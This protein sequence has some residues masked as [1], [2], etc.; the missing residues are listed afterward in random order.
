M[1][2][3]FFFFI[4]LSLFL[5]YFTPILAP[6]ASAA[7][8]KQIIE[9]D[10]ATA[11]AQDP[12]LAHEITVG[13]ATGV[14]GGC[15]K[16]K[17]ARCVMGKGPR[18]DMQ[19]FKMKAYCKYNDE[20]KPSSGLQVG[21]G[22]AEMHIK[23]DNMKNLFFYRDAMYWHA[24]LDAH[25]NLIR[26]VRLNASGYVQSQLPGHKNEKEFGAKA[27]EIQGRMENIKNEILKLTQKIDP[28]KAATEKEQ[29]NLA[30]GPRLIGRL[31]AL[32]DGIIKKVDTKYNPD[33]HANKYRERSEE[34]TS[35]YKNLV[36]Q[37]RKEIDNLKVEKEELEKAAS[38][39][40]ISVGADMDSA[41]I[42][43]GATVINNSEQF[44]SGKLTVAVAVATSSALK[45]TAKAMFEG[46][47]IYLP[48]DDGDIYS[49]ISKLK[50]IGVVGSRRFVEK[51]TGKRH[52]L[53]MSTQFAGNS[54][55]ESER[56]LILAENH[57][58]L[59]L[60]LAI[61]ANSLSKNPTRMKY[62][63]TSDEN[64]IITPNIAQTLRSEL[65]KMPLFG[66]KERLKRK[67][68]W[69]G[70]NQ[71]VWIVIYSISP[72]DSAKMR[73]FMRSNAE[74][75]IRINDASNYWKGYAK[76]LNSEVERARNATNTE[77][78]GKQDAKDDMLGR[79]PPKGKLPSDDPNPNSDIRKI[80]EPNSPIIPKGWYGT[81]GG[82]LENL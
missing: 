11:L 61:K 69:P 21:V 15:T 30:Q 3:S 8:P 38:G 64:L 34:R 25:S 63:R 37:Y 35:R 36:K 4:S 65:K 80:P 49:F 33:D 13:Q 67:I 79:Y 39:R 53:G 2:H 45:D 1:K 26:E 81:G 27:G 12:K 18:S 56:N 23:A 70:L 32:L 59:A 57:A 46:Q 16:E 60:G 43:L 20:N 74:D 28:L 19:C 62:K 47:P 66:V 73:D 77:W 24:I 5:L 17:K 10:A 40:E 48:S 55:D 75:A 50:L 82:N 78:M 31:K 71:N 42:L 68:R 72:S 9:K 6:N 52:I 7:G 58:L 22:A 14:T 29:L 76:G 41:G 51:S 44:K 54:I